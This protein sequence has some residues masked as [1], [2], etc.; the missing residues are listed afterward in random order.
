MLINAEVVHVLHNI[1]EI[2]IKNFG[3]FELALF[4]RKID[5]FKLSEMHE[6]SG[7]LEGPHNNVFPFSPKDV[8]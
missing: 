8:M 4:M 2:I 6:I 3:I 7:V 1:G 5:P